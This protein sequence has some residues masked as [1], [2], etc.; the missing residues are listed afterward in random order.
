MGT[1]F[2]SIL[3]IFALILTGF[4]LRKA[5]I[6]PAQN[7]AVIEEVCFWLFFPALLTLTLARADL[8]NLSLGTIGAT[9]FAV[10]LT[11]IIAVLALRPVLASRFGVKGPQFTTIFQTSTRWHGFIA[12]AI[13]LKLYGNAGGAVVAIVF[14]LLIPLL[15]VVNILVL[16][17]YGSGQTPSLFNTARTIISNPVIWSCI[18]GMAINFA[19]ITLWEPVVTYLDLLGR[20]ALGAS[21]LAL[22]AGL[23]LKA[24]LNSSHDVLLGVFF[25]LF[26]TP[27]LMAAYGVAF[28]VTAFEMKV[29]LICASVSTAMNGYIFARKMGGDA[30]LY[31][32]TAT[33]QT[34]LSFATIP[35][36]IWLGELLVARM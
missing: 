32:S 25:K 13:I 34:I 29:L 19:G 16:A 12:L 33:V 26:A 3:P 8:H 30:E 20:A 36:V 31:A 17:T 11:V 22:G 2:E 1:V 28:G 18:V 27:A 7:W 9:V 15:Q 10:S 21:L 14:A 35:L 24:A 5:N 23:S 4:G 6:F